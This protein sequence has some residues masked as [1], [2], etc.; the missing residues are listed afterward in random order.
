[1]FYA[2]GIFLTCW[3]YLGFPAEA[4][5]MDVRQFEDPFGPPTQECGDW[6]AELQFPTTRDKWAIRTDFF[7]R[8]TA[9]A[10]PVGQLDNA[11]VEAW[12]DDQQIAHPVDYTNALRNKLTPQGPTDLVANPQ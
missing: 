3:G 1:M 9:T 5:Y 6:I 7:E 4:C 10:C 8:F 12:L 11:T 2:W